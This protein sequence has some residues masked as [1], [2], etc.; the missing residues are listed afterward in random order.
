MGKNFEKWEFSENGKFPGN[1]T[2]MG[3]LMRASLGIR[4]H[5]GSN[6]EYCRK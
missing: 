4:G 6:F 1:I 5:T 2:E 3:G